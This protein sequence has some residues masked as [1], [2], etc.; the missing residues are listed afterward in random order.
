VRKI[1][2]IKIDKEDLYKPDSIFDF[3]FTY[4]V[5]GSEYMKHILNSQYY[6]NGFKDVDIN[7][8]TPFYPFLKDNISTMRNYFDDNLMKH[9]IDDQK[10]LIPIM[11]YK[12]IDN[13][14]IFESFITRLDMPQDYIGNVNKVT[15]EYNAYSAEYG[16]YGNMIINNKYECD[17]LYNYDGTP[18]TYYSVWDKRCEKNED[19]P[20]FKSNTNY[21]NERG[22]CKDGFCEFPVGVK[23]LGFTKYDDTCLNTPLCYECKDTTN[24]DCCK[25]SKKPDYVFANDS[26]DRIKYNL[27]TIITPLQYD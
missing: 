3:C 2:I 19:C 10:V 15:R 17:S 16:C 4:I 7:R 22:G 8:L 9:Y 24:L 13:V 12:I 6:I 1:N 11:K 26:K 23:R 25:N 14:N 20:Y 5:I 21:P 18:K 27:N